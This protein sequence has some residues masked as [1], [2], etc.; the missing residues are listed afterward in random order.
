MPLIRPTLRQIVARVRADVVSLLPDLDP[1]IPASF[2]RALVESFAIRIN[3]ANLLIDQGVREAFPQTATGANLERFAEGLSRNPASNASGNI[4][5]YGTA[6][7]TVPLE[8]AM[9][10][11]SGAVYRTLETVQLANRS[12]LISSL[13]SSGGLATAVANGHA[14]ASGQDATIAGAADSEYNGTFA[15]T[16]IDEDTFSYAV[17][18]SPNSPTSGTI[19]A[20]FSGSLA[21]VRSE[22]V[23]IATNLESG[24]KLTLSS[25]IAGVDSQAIVRFDGITGGADLE[26]D[27][28]LRARILE[29]R[30][31]IAAN[32]SADSIVLK[33]KEIA[34]VTRVSVLPA[35]PDPGDVTVQFVRDGDTNIIPSA[36]D[37]E[38]VRQKIL[39]ILPGTAEEAS[40]VVSAPSAVSQSF[41]FSSLSPNTEAMKNAVR[42]SLQAFFADEVQI[43][44]TISEDAYRAAI[45]QTVAG[46]ALLQSFAL[47]SPSGDIAITA[48]QIGILGDVSFP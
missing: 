8:T 41:A 30:A 47:S 19:T 6:L 25:P 21:A 17:S 29:K 18:G 4:V 40:L 32:F 33:A 14:L 5:L 27:D 34:G 12:I 15:I 24:A 48:T 23:G 36:I 39:E 2:I 42:A 43:G 1:T 38:T 11:K 20:S 46:D 35:T 28:S 9:T 16:V 44:V 10:A 22:G 45:A 13:T 26:N 3:A 37:V 7:A 31:A